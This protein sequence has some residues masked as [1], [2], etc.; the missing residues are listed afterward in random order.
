MSTTLRGRLTVL[1]EPRWRRVLVVGWVAFAI[2]YPLPTVV[3]HVRIPSISGES[4]LTEFANLAGWE[5]FLWALGGAAGPLGVGSAV[6]S[7]LILGSALHGKWSPGARWPVLVLAAATI[8][9]AVFWPFWVA[10]EGDKSLQIGYFVWGL[11][12]SPSF[13]ETGKR[14][15]AVAPASEIAA[16][17]H[18]PDHLA[19]HHVGKAPPAALYPTPLFSRIDQQISGHR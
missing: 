15:S 5:A 7:V 11:P 8:L 1:L 16:F 14:W 18:H 19:L 2:S 3:S 6:T 4:P 17:S 12:A 9:N 13:R 10:G